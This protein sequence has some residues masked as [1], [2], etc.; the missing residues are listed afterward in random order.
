MPRW[1]E[2]KRFC[3]KDG[4]ELFKDTDHYYYRKIDEDG[5]IN[6][7]AKIS[8]KGGATP[9]FPEEGKEYEIEISAAGYPT[10]SVAPAK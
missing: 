10:P 2:L 7:A 8:G 5:S 6:F 3:E 4:W 1:K 9:A